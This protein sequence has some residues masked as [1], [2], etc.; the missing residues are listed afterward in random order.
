M[1]Y[2]YL[3]KVVIVIVILGLSII[4]LIIFIQGHVDSCK[5]ALRPDPGPVDVD[6]DWERD[7][8]CS[9]TAEQCARPVDPQ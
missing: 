8:Q 6:D 7:Q 9:H 5:L 3:N 4:P 1:G 2:L